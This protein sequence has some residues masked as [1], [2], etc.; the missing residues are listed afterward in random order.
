MPTALTDSKPVR[1]SLRR[2]V[3]VAVA[4]VALAA[5]VRLPRLWQGLWLDEMTTLTRFVQQPWSTVLAAG[6]GQ[7]VPNN[8]VLHTV[9]AKLVYPSPPPDS[10]A[11]PLLRLPS[12]AAASVLPVAVAWPLRRRSPGAALAVAVVV[13]LHPWLVVLGAEARGYSLML[14]LGVVATHLLPT[15]RT[16]RWRMTA[17]AVTVAAAIYTV[18]LAVLL[19]PA[20]A[21]AVWATSRAGV[22]RF[23]VAAAA[24]LGLAVVLYLPMAR[25]LVSYYRHPFTATTTEARLLDSV[26]RHALAGLRLPPHTVDPLLPPWQRSWPADPPSAAVFWAVPVLAVVLGSAVGWQRFPDARPLL[27]TLGTATVLGLLLPLAVP[28]AAEVRFVTWAAP[29]FCL[30]VVL[31]LASAAGTRST[32]G[33][34]AAGVGLLVLVGQFAVWDTDRRPNQPVREAI[35]WAD[36]HAPPGRAILV[37][38]VGALEAVDC[39]AGD[40]ATHGLLA[41]PDAERF[42]KAT[43]RA[44]QTTGHLPYVIVPFE[45]LTRDREPVAIWRPLATDYVRV[46]RLPGRL[47]PVAVFAPR[48]DAAAGPA[49][50][51]SVR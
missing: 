33:R 3:W 48:E 47:V 38:Y 44:R 27:A 14:L 22:G 9:L 40:A 1:R 4:V 25:G 11:E 32:L 23:A 46:A 20:H 12:W 42:A 17:Y 8:H 50:A 7:Y 41:V 24:A 45:E 16:S 29:W 15:T 30:A 6:P 13:A 21:A 49:V 35:Q 5:A 51:G 28:A 18:P 43:A 26:P 34:A 19:L 10:P 37:A 31:L 39:Y 2:D 36:Q